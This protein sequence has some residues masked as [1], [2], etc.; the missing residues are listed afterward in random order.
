M[1]DPHAQNDPPF[2]ARDALLALATLLEER[3]AA[4]KRRVYI[5][6]Q[7]LDAGSFI[8][9]TSSRP[10]LSSGWREK[11]DVTIVSNTRTLCDLLLGRLDAK[12]PKPGQ[13]FLWGGEEETLVEIS[14]VLR[15][16]SSL[17]DA[18]LAALRSD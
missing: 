11:T 3:K 9:D 18:H 17:L 7:V 8:L 10:M 13:L 5:A 16:G 4:I 15:A 14:R 12:A 1:N 6:F 2:G